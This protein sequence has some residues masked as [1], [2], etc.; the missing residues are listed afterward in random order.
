MKLKKYRKYVVF[1]IVALCILIGFDFPLSAYIEGPGDA[2][3]L[4]PIVNIKGHPDRY[5]GKFML[6]SVNISRATPFRYLYA[7]MLPYYS[8]ESPNDV[9]GGTNNNDFNRVQSFYMKSAINEAI[10]TGYKNAHQQVTNYYRGI[11]VINV[12]NN[13]KFKHHLNIGDTILKVNGHH[14][15]SALGY[16]N[17]IE[18]HQIG[19]KIAITYLHHGRVQT[20]SEPLTKLYGKKAGIGI[21]LTDDVDTHTKIPIKV[22]PGQIGGPSGG[23]MFSLQIY[24][25]L[26]GKNIR[27]NQNIAGTGTINADGQ[28]GEIGGID[29]KIIAAKRKNAKIFLSPYIKPT[30]SDLSE[31]PGH[32][33]NYQLAVKT[34]K[35]YAPKMKVIPVQTFQEALSAIKKY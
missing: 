11:Y 5:S 23:L 31:E 4:K 17:Y 34:A 9:T 18:R 1:A 35:K 3:N 20:V 26:T 8:I 30:R 7:K 19:T 25:Q 27:R 28:V 10:Y 14:F 32:I 6:M 24:G 13:S 16:Q 2:T 22:D 21:E 33:T 15:S 29:K 12:L